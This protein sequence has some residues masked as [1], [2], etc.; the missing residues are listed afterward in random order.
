MISSPD[1][2][3]SKGIAKALKIISNYS[4]WSH[5]KSISVG[6]WDIGAKSAFCFFL[7]RVIISH[8]FVLFRIIKR[9]KL[10]LPIVFM[11]HLIYILPV[12]LPL[13]FVLD[14]NS[15][16]IAHRMLSRG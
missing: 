11:P 5:I 2:R 1:R 12:N 8:F 6:F 7:S 4:I 3:F 14:V 9:N 10:N 13:Q 15:G 16:A